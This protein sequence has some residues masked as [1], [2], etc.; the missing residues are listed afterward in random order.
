MTSFVSTLH[1]PDSR[2]DPFS[3]ARAT[4][5]YALDAEGSLAKAV[6][7]TRSVVW[8]L[9]L[10]G[11]VLWLAFEY[12]YQDLLA[13]GLISALGV[14]TWCLVVYMGAVFCTAPRDCVVAWCVGLVA[15]VAVV[16][17]PQVAVWVFF[18]GVIVWWAS[19]DGIRTIATDWE[20]IRT[21][22]LIIVSP[23]QSINCWIGIRQLRDAR[24]NL[25]EKLRRFD[26]AQARIFAVAPHFQLRAPQRITNYPVLPWCGHT[27]REVGDAFELWCGTIL[28][29]LG[30]RAAVCGR[31][32]D[33]G[34][35]IRASLATTGDVAVQCKYCSSSWRDE[36]SIREFLRDA[37]RGAM[38][39]GTRYAILMTTASLADEVERFAVELGVRILDHDVLQMLAVDLRLPLPKTL[40]ERPLRR[41]IGEAHDALRQILQATAP[42]RASW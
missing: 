40:S 17:N 8:L 18:G 4:V 36:R 1:D 32:G 41:E 24:W 22:A 23:K 21:G 31:Q 26:L 14:V 27:N 37:K 9:G 28:Q 3:G 20:V 13:S 39:L 25:E 16:V 5:R 33:G 19:R 12:R 42:L 30:A 7:T 11:V 35:D 10:W 34:V 38:T 15:G 2:S 29:R 6:G